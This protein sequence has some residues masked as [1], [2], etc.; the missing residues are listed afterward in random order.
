VSLRTDFAAGKR[1]KSLRTNP[2]QIS[3]PQLINEEKLP[4]NKK[5]AS[6]K[7]LLLCPLLAKLSVSSLERILSCGSLPVAA[8]QGQKEEKK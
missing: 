3:M 4:S 2:S 6:P 5:L 8:K 7:E 1:R